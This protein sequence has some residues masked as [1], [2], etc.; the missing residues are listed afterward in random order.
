MIPEHRLHEDCP[1]GRDKRAPKPPVA[2]ERPASPG[3]QA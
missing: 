3:G 2:H 1:K